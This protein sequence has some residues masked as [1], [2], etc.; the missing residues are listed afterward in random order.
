MPSRYTL[1]M[2]EKGIFTLRTAKDLFGKLEHD[3]ERFKQNPADSFAAFDFFVTAYHL[4]EWKGKNKAFVIQNLSPPDK[5]MWGTCRQ[6]ANGSKHFEV[7]HTHSSVKLTKLTEGGFQAGAFQANAFQVPSLVVRLEAGPARHLGNTIR[8]DALAERFAGLWKGGEWQY[9]P[10]HDSIITAGNGGTQPTQAAF[11]IFYNQGTQM[12]QLEQTLQP[13]DQMWMDIGKLIRENV[14]DKNGKT[15]PSDLASGSYEVRDLTNKAVG[16]LFEG[17]VIYDKTYGHVTYGCG[18]CCGG[19]PPIIPWYDP[20]SVVITA[21]QDNGV[22]AWYS[23]EDQYDDVSTTFYYNWSSGSTSVATVNSYGTVTGVSIGSTTAG[24]YAHLLSNGPKSCPSI[25]RTPSGGLNVQ[26]KIFLGGCSGTNITNTTQS[27]VVGQQI[28]LRASYGGVSANSQ[29][30][31][32]PGTIVGGFTIAPTLQSGGPTPATLNAQSTTFYWV[33]SGNS[34]TITFS[35]NYGSNQVATAQATFN[36][37]GPT[38]STQNAPFVT[39]SLGPVAIN[40]ASPYPFLQFGSTSAG[41]PGILYTAS[42]NQPAG[43]SWSFKWINIISDDNVTMTDTNGTQMTSLGTGFDSNGT[44]PSFSNVTANT[45][46]DS[47]KFQLI[48][49][50]TEIKRTLDAQTY[51]MW[52]AGLTNP[53]SIDIPLGSLTWGFS[54]DAIMNSGTWS[55]NGTPTNYAAGFTN[56]STYPTWSSA[57]FNGTGPACP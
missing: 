13:G 8:A 9:D 55:I 16:T 24:T 54:G 35:L 17:K 32:V 42:T 19:D 20:I 2:P 3:F 28:A 52:N 25:Y 1:G 21:E 41:I 44:Y 39:T 56:G 14:P 4:R 49:P 48:P 5:A 45:T 38:P 27:A 34:Q 26:P 12:Y 15:L 43:Y 11:T 30:W 29:S 22:W 10:Q 6:L 33:T 18:G 40:S 51:L 47:P 50:C 53:A 46:S 36:I 7:D 37:A 31:S 57:H 23:C